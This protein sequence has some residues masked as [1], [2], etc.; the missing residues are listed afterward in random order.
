MDAVG[1]PRTDSDPATV[2]FEALEGAAHR[3][4]ADFGRWLSYMNAMR[5]LAGDRPR[6]RL[7]FASSWLRTGLDA[8]AVRHG[9]VENDRAAYL[10]S[11]DAAHAGRPHGA[12]LVGH[13]YRDGRGAR[14]S[15]RRARRWYRR[16]ARDGSVEA[17]FWLTATENHL[18]RWLLY[19]GPALEWVGV[20]LLCVHLL[21]V[22]WVFSVG[23]VLACVSV[24]LGG[25]LL[26]R[27]GMG[28]A[29]PEP[30]V[31]DAS[32]GSEV[33]GDLLA[34]PWR[35]VMVVGEDGLVLV[36][37][38]V[39]GSLLNLGIAPIAVAAGSLFGLLHHPNFG[40]RGCVAKGLT[41][42][43]AVA[44]VVPWGGVAALAVGHV[45]LDA[46]IVAL[47]WT[48]RSRLRRELQRG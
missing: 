37:L 19:R 48:E 11:L 3:D 42:A 12:V 13:C 25:Q 43:L 1:T 40:W 28:R 23:A 35:I 15:M 20:T 30:G 36:P 41:Y 5:S 9:A 29:M 32:S 10:W 7:R 39:V 47:A 14:R 38:L 46:F 24:V 21:L 22:P 17:A 44:L 31:P 18:S 4:E 26:V 34:K 2:R 16:G 27:W 8:S 33:V 6:L 45:L